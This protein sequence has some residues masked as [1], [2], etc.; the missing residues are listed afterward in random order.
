MITGNSDDLFDA[1][2]ACFGEV[3]KLKDSLGADHPHILMAELHIR[4]INER[5]NLYEK[6]KKEEFALKMKLSGITVV[7]MDNL[8]HMLGA[9]SRYKKSQWGFRNHYCS[10]LS[11]NDYESMI[12][13]EKQ[14]LVKRGI[15]QEN[16]IFFHA[17]EEGCK[18]IGFNSRQIKKTFED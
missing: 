9:D 14:G 11:G 5:K 12:R 1:S 16:S 2:L 7:D 17:K 3:L 8:R 10:S 13:M 4:H 18:A 6:Q 15:Q